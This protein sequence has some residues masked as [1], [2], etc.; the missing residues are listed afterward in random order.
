MGLTVSTLLIK[1]RHQMTAAAS[2]HTAI[3]ILETK[4]YR[5]DSE[6]ETNS[7]A[8]VCRCCPSSGSIAKDVNKCY[9]PFMK[10][11]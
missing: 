5:L 9:L 1:G 3:L 8:V 6:R 10:I 2:A 7:S 4:S 11:E